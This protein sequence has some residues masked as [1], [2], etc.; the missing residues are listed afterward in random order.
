MMV[1]MW[2]KGD[3]KLGSEVHIV[4]GRLCEDML[5]LSVVRVVLLCR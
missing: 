2:G 4:S 5:I 1:R 3:V